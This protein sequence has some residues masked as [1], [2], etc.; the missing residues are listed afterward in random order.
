MC[1]V[2]PDSWQ[3]PDYSPAGSSVLG[4]SQGRILRWIAMFCSR[5]SSHLRDWTHVS[6]I[7]A[8]KFFTFGP[9]GKS[10]LIVSS[11]GEESACN[12]GDLDSIPGLGRSPGEGN[13]NPLGNL[14]WR[15]PWTEEAG[16]LQS[17][18]SKRVR[19][20]WTTKHAACTRIRLM[21]SLTT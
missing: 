13:G 20:D 9:P 3:S 19:Q 16:E 2:L 15:I 5:G 21:T 17:M 1:S 7:S 14:A 18:G 10:L 6:C 11:D 8:G 4:I 12:V